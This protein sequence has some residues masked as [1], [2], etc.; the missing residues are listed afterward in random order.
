MTTENTQINNAQSA[1]WFMDIPE[2]DEIVLKVKDFAI[3]SVRAGTT[4]LPTSVENL[5]YESG[6]R[7]YF[8]DLTITFFVDENFENYRK[9]LGWMK[10][11]THNNKAAMKSLYIHLLNSNREFQ[12]VEI[13]FLYAFPIALGD[14]R[15]D[16]DSHDT[17]ITCD[18]TFKYSSFEFITDDSIPDVE[19]LDIPYS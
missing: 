2:L 17:D 9:V 11:N 4:N 8:E 6:D 16:T 10:Q 19:I 14:I 3:P 15:M 18:V 12:G 13:E 1:N 7:I 5:Y